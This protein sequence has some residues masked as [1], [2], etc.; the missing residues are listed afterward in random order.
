MSVYR[1]S[2]IQIGLVQCKF[3]GGSING[4]TSIAG[5]FRRGNPTRGT[6]IYG[7]PD[8]GNNGGIGSNALN[9][10]PEPMNRTTVK[11]VLNVFG[12]SMSQFDKKS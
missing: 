10:A 7:N 5:W 12:R 4:D 11:R 2:S 8:L 6:P 9:F 3:L 1:C